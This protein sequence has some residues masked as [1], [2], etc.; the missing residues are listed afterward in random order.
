MQKMISFMSTRDASGAGKKRAFMSISRTFLLICLACWSVIAAANTEIKGDIERMLA[1]ED[2]VVNGVKILAL[3]I[4]RDVYRDHGFEPYWTDNSNIRELMELINEAADHGLNPQDY[5][6]V[7]LREILGQ[8]QKNPSAEIAAEADIMLTESLLRYGY[9]RRL[10]KAN[11][12]KIDPDINFRRQAFRDQPPART[13]E[14][15]LAADSLQGF[16]DM[17]AP[18][19]PFY[20]RIQ[21]W[22]EQYRQIAADGGWPMVPGGP[23]LRL[24]DNDSR[25][26]AIRNRLA[27]SGDLP[28]DAS[29]GSSSYDETLKQAVAAFQGRHSLD[30]D[31]IVGKQTIAAMNVT[32]AQRIDQLRASLERLRW[33]NQE[34]A[35]TLVAVNIAGFKAYFYQEGELK[36]ST[37]AMVGKSYRRTP[38]F[39]GDIQYME[40]NPTWTIPPGILRNDT[41][42]AIK[43]DPNYLSS[44]NIR[45]IDRNG[46][47]IDPA[48]VDWNQYSKGVPYTLRQDPGPNNALGTVKFI[49]PNKHF[50]FLHDTP[51]RELFDRP[52]RAFSS[53]CIRVEDPLT[54]AGLLLD[55]DAYQ[56]PEL[57][58]V[59]ATRETQRIHLKNTV[60]V[61]I[62][63]LTA[64]LS[65]DGNVTFHKDIY[66]RDDKVLSALDGAVVIEP[67]GV[68]N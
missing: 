18:S 25:V 63:Y 34:A 51:H 36:W 65:S 54:L 66:N 59:V 55:D 27:T 28:A 11:P 57:E 37:R 1:R 13:L 43:R 2:L 39:R 35:D 15:I 48:T 16:I 8:R 4:I 20:Q 64:S 19:G 49:F 61:I 33:V 52:E 22:L 60:P 53:G 50:V 9:H 3:D 68:G 44:K 47:L 30:A 23:T 67:P 6:M 42:P 46:S 31:G 26:T 5:N 21:Y 14:E 29:K 58:A 38:V 24:G 17:A 56:R 45:V 32:V 41:L 12:G 7:Q 40:F 62:I 10:G